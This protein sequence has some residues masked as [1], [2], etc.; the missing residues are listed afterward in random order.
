MVSGVCMSGN[1]QL[2]YRTAE[3]V[4]KDCTYKIVNLFMIDGLRAEKPRNL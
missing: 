1:R 3:Y 4:D 2:A